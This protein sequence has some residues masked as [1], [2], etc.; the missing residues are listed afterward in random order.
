[1]RRT[2]LVLFWAAFAVSSSRATEFEPR[3]FIDKPPAGV[4]TVALTFD[5]CSGAVDRRVL[6]ALLETGAKATIFVT[7]RWLRGN[8]DALGVM[9]AHP[10]Q[11]ELENHG[12][13]HVPT[14]TDTARIFGV[15]TAGTMEAVRAEIAG[16]AEAVTKATG[17]KPRWFRSATARYTRDAMEEAGAQGQRIA[18]YSLN[19][20]IGASLPAAS[21]EKRVAAAKS[22]DVVIG[23]INQPTRAAGGGLAAGIRA[24]KASGAQFVR[25]D[26]VET[27]AADG[28]PISP[29]RREVEDQLHVQR[30][31]HRGDDAGR[32]GHPAGSHELPHLRPAGGEPDQRD[33]GEGKL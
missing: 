5:A 28:P 2:A 11:F 17:A 31:D 30:D 18:G 10:E 21:V 19:A 23:H 29:P 14:D 25:L 6:D 9:K 33:H 27:R 12:A 32:D 20:D 3:L 26:E 16:G 15:R 7:G 4:R 13:M 8:A 1:M 24:L 22:G